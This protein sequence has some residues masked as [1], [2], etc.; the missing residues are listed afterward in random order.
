MNGIRK[1][2]FEL[3]EIKDEDSL[4][5]Y[6]P[7]DLK[8]K[9]HELCLIYHPDKNKSF[10]DNKYNEY[11]FVDVKDAYEYLIDYKLSHVNV[12]DS[13]ISSNASYGELWELF[14]SL[15][16]MDNLQKILNYIE[17]VSK[18]S[19]LLETI[20]Y[21]VTFEQVYN[22][23]VF[24]D[25]KYK[26]YIPLWHNIVR[27]NDIYELFDMKK[28]EKNPIY[29]ISVIDLLKNVKILSNN[30]VLVKLSKEK[31]KKYV[32]DKKLHILLSSSVEKIVDYTECRI[33]NEKE[34][35]IYEKQG[36]P[37]ICASNLYDTQE[38]SNLI[39]IIH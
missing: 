37:R 32:K 13:T 34:V 7:R 26:V 8:K 19:K 15:F 38:I 2:A 31:L 3:F 21:N 35:K 12:R 9:Y 5:G 10:K 14:D 36:I 4:C 33:V 20:Q 6:T 39:V 25:E 23:N 24:F 17:K 30:D 27:L 11:N 18:A 22:K 16:N 28:N 29:K 1:K